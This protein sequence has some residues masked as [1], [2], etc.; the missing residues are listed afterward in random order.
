VRHNSRVLFPGIYGIGTALPVIVFSVLVAFAT[1]LVGRAFN[2][3]TVFEKW[4]RRVTAI[5][6]IGAGIYISLKYIF[7]IPF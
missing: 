6:F 4:A 3:L 7:N 2:K 5:I 1:N